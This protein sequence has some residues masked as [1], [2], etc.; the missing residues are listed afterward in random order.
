VFNDP[1]APRWEHWSGL[2]FRRRPG[3]GR[4]STDYQLPL[5][6]D[7]GEETG[8]NGKKLLPHKILREGPGCGN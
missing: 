1:F 3:A 8:R 6:S 2:L 7:C 4:S 5:Q